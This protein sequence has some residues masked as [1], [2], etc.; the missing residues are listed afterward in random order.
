MNYWA[1]ALFSGL[2]LLNGCSLFRHFT[3]E[4]IGLKSGEAIYLD[5]DG[6]YKSDLRM[7]SFD[8]NHDGK[9]EKACYFPITKENGADGEISLN[10]PIFIAM[11]LL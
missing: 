2:I 11:N 6:D 10:L 5:V 9:A 8:S 3:N 4:R 1:N 7:V